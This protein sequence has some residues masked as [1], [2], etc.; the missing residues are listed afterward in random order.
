RFARQIAEQFH[1]E[2]I[3]LFGSYA[4]GTPHEDSDVDLLVIMEAYN[5]VNQSISICLAFERPFRY[6]LIVRTPKQIQRG[7]KDNDWF[8]R[9]ITEKGKV[10]YEA[11]ASSVDTQSGGRLARSQTPRQP[12]AATV[13]SRVLP[14]S[15]IGRKISQSSSVPHGRSRAEGT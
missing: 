10:L 14:L 11:P 7:I 8:L 1:P 9:E 5:V 12:K 4:Y 6:D 2:K 13:R 15:A 3:I